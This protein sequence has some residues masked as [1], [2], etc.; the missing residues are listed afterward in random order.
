L[1]NT[2]S[3]P[4]LVALLLEESDLSDGR[5]ENLARADGFRL[6][7]LRAVGCPLSPGAGAALS[8]APWADSLRILDLSGSWLS[9]PDVYAIVKC[10]KFGQLQHLNLAH[11]TLSPRSLAALAANPA[12][13]GLRALDIQGAIYSRQQNRALTSQHFEQFLAS[14]EWPELRQ[15]DLSQRPV[16]P[17][18][19]RHL[20][21]PKFS[22]LRRLGLNNC[23]LTEAVVK[24][25]LTAPTL[26]NL[27]GLGLAHNRLSRSLELLVN[28]SVLPRLS[29]CSLLGNSLPRPLARKLRRRPGVYV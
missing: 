3:F 29:A 24:K 17:K 11:T 10:R 15:L 22:S 23:Q 25:L 19:A 26:N 20:L 5:W 18:A 14:I 4:R 2:R 21:H 12:L 28:R 1:A 27:I 13:R 8:A 6:R 16:G 9:S 7:V